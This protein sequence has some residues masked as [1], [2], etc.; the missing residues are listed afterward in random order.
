MS[1][2]L[3][4]YLSLVSIVYLSIAQT[5]NYVKVG[6]GTTCIGTSGSLSD[7]GLPDQQIEYDL[8]PMHDPA[9][10]TIPDNN[11]GPNKFLTMT[12]CGSLNG[13]GSACGN[14]DQWCFEETHTNGTCIKGVA[15]WEENF[16]YGS[17]IEYEAIFDTA[18]YKQQDGVGFRVTVSDHSPKYNITCPRDQAIIN[19]DIICDPEHG[20]W[21]TTTFTEN[22]TNC[23]WNVTIRSSLGC[24]QYSPIGSG[25]NSSDNLSAGSVFL[26]IFIVIFLTY[27][28]LGCAYNSFYHGRVGMDAVPNKDTWAQFSRYTRAG[29]ELTRD[30][31][32]CSH[33]PGSYQEL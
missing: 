8:T 16:E 27:V 5:F 25:S 29:C 9:G 12:I 28:I 26:I 32:C 31:I 10:R 11:L 4:L 3:F 13:E 17:V 23:N 19:Y 20:T 15:N 14:T 1:S 6:L 7:I 21:G 33:S 18:G 22:A 24:F 30:T 2:L